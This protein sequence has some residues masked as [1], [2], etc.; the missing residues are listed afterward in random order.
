MDSF[1]SSF[2]LEV[3]SAELFVIVIFVPAK[4][5]RIVDPL[6]TLDIRASTGTPG[7]LT[8]GLFPG[9]STPEEH[10]GVTSSHE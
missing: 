1:V 2:D 4:T 9:K 10:L 7:D 6:H 5:D 3:S 8:G